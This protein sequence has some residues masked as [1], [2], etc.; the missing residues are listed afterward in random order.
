[1]IATFYGR[2]GFLYPA[3]QRAYRIR[4]TALVRNQQSLCSA[5]DLAMCLLT[6][7]LRLD[8]SAHASSVRVEPVGLRSACHGLL[9]GHR[10]C[11]RSGGGEACHCDV[12]QADPDL[13]TG[14]GWELDVLLQ[15]R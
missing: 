6:R 12:P 14:M 8:I 11:N 10:D 7:P 5:P 3:V 13:M 4:D 15:E 2:F 9:C 1:M